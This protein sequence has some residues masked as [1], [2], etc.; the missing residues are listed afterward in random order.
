MQE[1][2]RNSLKVKWQ[3]NW[4]FGKLY[5]SVHV[6]IHKREKNRMMAFIVTEG[7]FFHFGGNSLRRVHVFLRDQKK[8]YHPFFEPEM[9]V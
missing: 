8:T 1:D 4:K 5:I 2:K 6:K 7:I 3:Q 9:G